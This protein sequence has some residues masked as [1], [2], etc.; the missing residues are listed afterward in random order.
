VGDGR[1]WFI[2][3][4]RVE[5]RTGIAVGCSKYRDFEVEPGQPLPV[6]T[7]EEAASTIALP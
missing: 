2:P 6:R 5:G 4:A 7:N 3:A 1:R